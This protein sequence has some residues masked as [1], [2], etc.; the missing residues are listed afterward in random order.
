MAS[1]KEVLLLNP[2]ISRRVANT[3]N[4]EV[5]TRLLTLFE[6]SMMLHAKELKKPAGL[7]PFPAQLAD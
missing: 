5:K 4:A 6:P 2:R 7:S 3:G 1:H